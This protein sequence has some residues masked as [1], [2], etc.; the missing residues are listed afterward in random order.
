M[1]PPFDLSGKIAGRLAR[2]R[3]VGRT[4][5]LAGK[6]MAARAGRKP[7]P[8]VAAHVKDGCGRDWAGPRGERHVGIEGG[9]RLSLA[10]GEPRRDPAH[11]R[12]LPPAVGIGFKLPPEIAE[13]E[14]G[15]ARGSR[16]V[17]APVQSVAGEAGV[18]RPGASA[19]ERYDLAGRTEAC[20]RRPLNRA[21]GGLQGGRD[22]QAAKAGSRGA[23]HGI[24]GTAGLPR[25]FRK[26]SC[27]ATDEGGPLPKARDLLALILLA[28]ACKPPPEERQ[29]MPLAS[30]E[31]GKQAIE[32]VGCAS[33]HTI[34]GID[35]PSGAVAPPIAGMSGRALIA[36]RLPNEPDMLARFV[37][38]AP[39]LLPNTTM[40]AMP[41]SEQESRDVAAYL[42][43][44]GD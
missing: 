29:T 5:A 1:A 4:D 13:V 32:R 20:G 14:V 9:N 37:R 40:P 25:R 8:R 30:A 24:T 35:W 10:R 2:K 19:A 3:R 21:A 7:A 22:G 18:P 17:A 23:D 11:L 42:Y 44:I 12:V 15:E 34:A 33:C 36:G 41:L 31:R 28:G 38:D 6:A 16:P 39:A 43:E 26:S 27:D